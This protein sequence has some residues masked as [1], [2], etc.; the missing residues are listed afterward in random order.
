M[1]TTVK[2]LKG[3]ANK[4]A[5][6]FKNGIV[7]PIFENN[8]K[9]YVN[10]ELAGYKELKRGYKLITGKVIHKVVIKGWV[11]RGTWIPKTKET[12]AIYYK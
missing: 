7:P 4:N 11:W 3:W 6:L 2:T 1:K 12:I 10:K 9:E 5:C 8:L